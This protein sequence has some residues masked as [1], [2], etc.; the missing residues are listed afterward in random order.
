MVHE[1]YQKRCDS[2]AKKYDFELR[3]IRGE[4]GNCKEKQQKIEELNI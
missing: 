2:V 4:L 3:K 1:E